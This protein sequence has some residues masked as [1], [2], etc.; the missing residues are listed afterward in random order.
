MALDFLII[1]KGENFT[2]ANAPKS[3]V[4]VEEN[5]LLLLLLTQ[6]DRIRLNEFQIDYN[7]CIYIY[8]LKNV[9]CI[10]II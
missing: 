4:I 2:S 10:Q 9:P 5:L 7:V 1:T 6:R 3:C 8:S